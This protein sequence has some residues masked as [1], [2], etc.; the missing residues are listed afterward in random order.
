M[1]PS[2][3]DGSASSPS[4]PGSERAEQHREAS[5]MFDRHQ[6]ITLNPTAAD[7]AVCA[8][9][10]GRIMYWRSARR[11][12]PG[13]SSRASAI[14]DVRSSRAARGHRESKLQVVESDRAALHRPQ[15]PLA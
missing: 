12:A 9:R 15:V 1:S 11:S 7:E 6:T 3:A 4:E 8:T 2:P 5:D 13:A 14:R 10:Y